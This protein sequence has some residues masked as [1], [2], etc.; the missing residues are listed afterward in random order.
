MVLA[1]GAS[2]GLHLHLSPDPAA[3]GDEL[4]VEVSAEDE[5]AHVRL[6]FA[7]F[8]PLEHAVDPPAQ[9]LE[10]KIEVPR[11]VRTSVVN[12]HAEVRTGK[13][14]TLRASAVLQIRDPLPL[15]E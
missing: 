1:H 15:R 5:I 12:C 7:G 3:R 10:L 6:A 14:K 9:Q 11:D 4:T 8:E 2:K 13:G